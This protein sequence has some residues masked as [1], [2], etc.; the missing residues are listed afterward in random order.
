M[1]LD[2]LKMALEG[3]RLIS[4]CFKNPMAGTRESNGSRASSKIPST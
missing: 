3:G 2:D 4:S 1:K